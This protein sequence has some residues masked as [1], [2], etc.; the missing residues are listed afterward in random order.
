MF[1]RILIA[2]RG[3]IALRIIRAARELGVE[4]VCVHSQADAD[5]PWLEFADRT[6]CIGPGPA[7]E[8]YLRVDRIIS[9]AEIANVDAIHPGYG[10]L[11]ENAHF[12]EVCR[13]C[14]IEFIGPS[15]EAMGLLGDKLSCRRMA[16]ESKT[17]VFPGSKDAIDNADDTV[18]LASEIGYP[19]IVKAS[20]GGGGRGMRVAHNEMALRSAIG[21]ASQ[22]AAAAFGNGAVYVE[23]FLEN[24]RHIEIQVLGDKHGNAV[25]LFDRDCTTQRRHQKL[26][27]EAP[28]PGVDARKREAVARSAADLIRRAEYAGAATVE[29]L[30]DEEQ[31]FYMLEVNTRVQV[32]HPVTEMITGIDIVKAMI[33]IAAGEPL[34]WKQRDIALSGHAVECRINAE[35][36][37]R[38]FIPQPGLITE[39][40]PPGGL[41][42]R[43]DTH[44]RT[45]YRIPPD[46]D[47]LIGKLIVHGRDRAQ[48]ISK[49][50]AALE[51]F[52]IGPIK[53]TIP[54]HRRLMAERQFL[55]AKHDIHY[56]ERLLRMDNPGPGEAV[57]A[58]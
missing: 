42:I 22:E 12:A 27:E 25:H 7:T 17:P 15:P 32:E 11:A 26:V 8:S 57:G 34:P 31:N 5:G 19:V 44:V 29:F 51:E 20:A 39:F 47:S 10:F 3:E 36:P 18:K 6:I 54:L 56:V 40:T 41:G 35:D 45:G 13:D 49:T 50:Q 14:H 52:R 30:M 4:T 58:R 21:A 2:N 38:G 48:A 24:A 53:T 16:R 1:T 46:Y 28:A 23:K 9:A 43:L 55:D 33:R 37:D